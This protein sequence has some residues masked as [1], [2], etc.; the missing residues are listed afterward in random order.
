MAG[1]GESAIDAYN[2]DAGSSECYGE[3]REEV[4]EDIEN[5]GENR[6]DGANKVI[7]D[8]LVLPANLLAPK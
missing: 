3:T 5:W 4:L 7:E 6:D 8:D 2:E 1:T